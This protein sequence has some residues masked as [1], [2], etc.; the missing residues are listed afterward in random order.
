MI[1]NIKVLALFSG[2]CILLFICCVPRPPKEEALIENFK[3]HRAAFEKLRD[4]L[5]A[6]TNLSRVASWGV[7]TRKPF[8]LGYPT[9]TN[10]PSKRFLQYLTLLNQANGYVG[11]RSDGDHADVGVIVWGSGFAGDTHHIG[12]YWMDKIPTNWEDASFKQIDHN[13]YLERD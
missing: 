2:I 5:E 13:W 3:A 7:D 6:D 11:V 4:M 9:E 12:F 1:K 10:F 8:F